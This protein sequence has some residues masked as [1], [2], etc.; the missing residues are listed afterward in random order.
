LIHSRRG[1][2]AALAGARLQFRFPVLLAAQVAWPILRLDAF[3]SG[4]SVDAVRADLLALLK[5]SRQ[6]EHVGLFHIAI[7]DDLGS[8]FGSALK[9]HW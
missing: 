2:R 3:L 5:R 8:A 6:L 9:L 7:Q 1:V 4:A